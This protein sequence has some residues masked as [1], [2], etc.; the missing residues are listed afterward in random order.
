M[1]IEIEIVE[2]V[3]RER[4]VQANGL[5]KELLQKYRVAFAE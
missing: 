4:E 1:G 5:K 2:K 3:F